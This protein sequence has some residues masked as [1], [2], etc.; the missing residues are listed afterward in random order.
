MHVPF[1]D[2]TL[3]RLSCPIPSITE[4]VSIL[5]HHFCNS[6]LNEIP[7]DLETYARFLLKNYI[8]YFLELKEVLFTDTGNTNNQSQ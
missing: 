6:G 5:L 4:K 8:W 2:I 1:P 3:R 7:P